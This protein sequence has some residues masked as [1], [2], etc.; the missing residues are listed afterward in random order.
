MIM[1]KFTDIQCVVWDL[2][3][4]LYAPSQRM[5]AGILSAV[6]AKIQKELGWDMAKVKKEFYAIYG[7][8]TQ[9]QT[10]TAAMICHMTTPQVAVDIDA[11]FTAHNPLPMDPSLVALFEQLS[12]F[13]HYILC[14][15]ATPSIKIRLTSLGLDPGIFKEII[16]SETVGVNKPHDNGFR[17]ILD[18]TG[19]P[20]GMHLMVGDREQVDLLPAKALGMRTCLVWSPKPSLIADATVPTVYELSQ[21]LL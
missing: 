13:Q 20:P 18:K 6:Y 12:G 10:E 16:T 15:G 19:L 11:Y 21:I 5:S 14:N 17:Y 2:D 3:G 7:K 8:V 9:S 4:T 1:Q